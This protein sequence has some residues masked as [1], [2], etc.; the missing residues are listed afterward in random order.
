[1]RLRV[2]QHQPR[3]EICRDRRCAACCRRW[4]NDR[5]CSSCMAPW[6]PCMNTFWCNLC[7]GSK[8]T[9]CC[10]AECWRVEKCQ[11]CEECEDVPN[12][13]GCTI[14]WGRHCTTCCDAHCWRD[15]MILDS[16]HSSDSNGERE[17]VPTRES[18][19]IH[20]DSV[21]VLTLTPRGHTDTRYILVLTP[22]LDTCMA[23]GSY[24]LA[25]VTCARCTSPVCGPCAVTHPPCTVCDRERRGE[26]GMFGGAAAMH[27]APTVLP[28]TISPAGAVPHGEHPVPP[29][30]ASGGAS[31][32]QDPPPTAREMI[33]SVMTHPTWIS[34]MPRPEEHSR[35]ERVVDGIV[36]GDSEFPSLF[37]DD[38]VVEIPWYVCDNCVIE[39]H[40]LVITGGYSTVVRHAKIVSLSRRLMHRAWWCVAGWWWCIPSGWKCHAEGLN[41]SWQ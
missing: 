19:P 39:L 29:P 8:C 18:S 20:A 26:Q 14:C 30:V 3:C 9:I 21:A 22:E 36:T 13:A 5:K 25:Y 15:G 41:H 40:G 32:G 2:M 16:D 28:L 6:I 4:C 34:A 27:H 33:Q 10:L 31:G 17:D 23:C 37:G 11:R 1:M 12:P 38:R 7:S 24:R 35:Q